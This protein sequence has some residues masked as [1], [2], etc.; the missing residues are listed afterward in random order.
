MEVFGHDGKKV[1]WEVVENH[2]VE[3]AADN[4]DIGLWGFDFFDE[5]ERGVGREGSSEFP[6][7]LILIKIWPGDWNNN[8]KRKNQKV[9]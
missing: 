5:D 7:L 4:D 9:N 3:E 1:F 8:L 2:V 6:Y